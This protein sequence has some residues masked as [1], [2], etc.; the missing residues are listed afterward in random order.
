MAVR[1]KAFGPDHYWNPLVRVVHVTPQRHGR[2]TVGV[3]FLGGV[4][5]EEPWEAMLAALGVECD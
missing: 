4:V 2:C 1:V 3:A 5:G